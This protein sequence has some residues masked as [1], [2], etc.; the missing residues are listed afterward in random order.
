MNN[1][2]QFSF[3]KLIPLLLLSWLCQA[4]YA[5]GDIVSQNYTAAESPGVSSCTA[6]YNFLS[7]DVE[8]GKTWITGALPYTLTYRAP[9]R[10]NLTAAQNFEQPEITTAGWVDNYQSH[11]ITANVSST[12]QIKKVLG[13]YHGSIFLERSP[14]YIYNP[15][16]VG[17]PATKYF[18][19]KRHY[20]RLPGESSDHVFSEQFSAGQST[21]YRLY[22]SDP[23]AYVRKYGVPELSGTGNSYWSSDT[24]EYTLSRNGNVLTVSKYGVSYSFTDTS[25]EMSPN[26]SV[27]SSS[28]A[29]YIGVDAEGYLIAQKT[30]PSDPER[31]FVLST[32]TTTG[33]V[34]L[35]RVAQVIY[36]NGTKLTIEY[37]SNMNLSK[38]SDNRNNVLELS[39]DYKKS[40][41]YTQTV[42]ETR[43]VTQVKLTSGSDTQTAT[44]TYSDYNVKIPQTGDP[45]L[46]Y[47]LKTG[48]STISSKYTYGYARTEIGAL[49]KYLQEIGVTYDTSYGFPVL[50]KITNQLGKLEQQWDITQNYI[51]S[52]SGSSYTTAKTTLRSY[53]ANPVDVA[54]T[55]FDSTTVYDDV[56]KTI[57]LSVAIDGTQTGTSTL[58]TTVDDY[59]DQSEIA[60]TGFPCLSVNKYPVSKLKFN[61]AKGQLTEST[62]RNGNISTY[63][64]DANNRLKVFQEA[65]NSTTLA[66]T[67]TYTYGALDGGAIN[68]YLV[69]TLI[70]KP[71]V[72]ITNVVNARGQLKTQKLS[73]AQAG[74]EDRLTAYAYYEDAALS[75]FGLI[76][77]VDGPRAGNT[78]R[79]RYYYDN[80]GNLYRKRMDLNG[81][82]RSDYYV[83]YN[84]QGKPERIVKPTGL[85][86]KF[87][88]NADGTVQ[89]VVVGV[90]NTTSTIT[91]KTTSYTYDALKRVKTETSPDGEVTTYEYDFVG[92]PFKVENPDGSLQIKAYY[93]IGALKSD[94]LF[95]STATNLF[96]GA[97]QTLDI[98]GR[99]AVSQSGNSEGWYLQSY[100]YDENG[101]L[102]KQTKGVS[103]DQWTYDELNRVKT[104]T[105]PLGFVDSKSYDL[106]NN[107]KSI[108]D[109]VG[110]GSN[111]FEY[112]NLGVL[113]KETN[114]DFGVKEYSHNSGD[115]LTSAVHG[116]RQCDY[117]PDEL[118]RNQQVVCK[119]KDGSGVGS[120][121]VHDDTYTYD[122]S[123]FGRLD[124]VVSA[125]GYGVNTSYVYDGYDR[126]ISK[127]Q[128]N[129][130]LTVWNVANA[131][132]LVVGYEYSLGDKLK[133][134][135]LPS[136]K[137]VAY[138][139]DAS[140][141]LTDIQ[142][143]SQPILRNVAYNGGGQLTGWKWSN[144]NASYTL[145]YE[146]RKN[147]AIS[148]IT[149]KNRSNAT[150]YG[151]TYGFYS[152]G[153]IKRLLR[154]DGSN[155]NYTYFSN[156]WLK[157]E[158]GMN[159]TDAV[160]SIGYTY[161]QNGNRK[162]LTATGTPLDG[163]N[164]A[165]YAYTGNKLTSY[166][167]NGA[168]QILNYKSN[169]ELG[170]A[171]RNPVYDFAGRRKRELE[172][173]VARFF[174]YNHKNERTL[175]SHDDG[176]WSV[177]TTQYVYDEASHLIGEYDRYGN[178]KVEYV[179][180]GDKPVAAIYPTGIYYIVTDAA[181][182]PHRLMN[183]ADDQLVWAW[184]GSAFGTG[185]P[186]IQTV[187]F[188]LRFPGQ[189]Y[190]AESGQHY[191]LN[192]FYNPEL[193]RY[194]EPDPIGL[195]G[196][197]N[198]YAYAG[199]NPVS[200]V[201]PSGLSSLNI[202]WP[203]FNS[204]TTITERTLARTAIG[205]GGALAEPTPF[206]EAA[207]T[208][209][210]IGVGAYEGY[211]YF[212]Q[213]KE[214]V[215]PSGIKLEVNN[216][217]IDRFIFRGG[218]GNNTNFTP[219]PVDTGGLSYYL[220]PPAKGDYTFT[221]LSAVNSTK[222]LTAVV[223]AA[224]HASV[225]PTNRATM[226]EWI[227]SRPN[228][229]QAPHPYTL[230]MKG[231]SIRMKSGE[232]PW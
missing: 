96:T 6:G 89:S 230:L 74:S 197:L 208:V 222:V 3:L 224:N 62:D 50:R 162:T 2:T 66:R 79:V 169:A 49:K 27:T 15:S 9:L 94:E 191:N 185:V 186:T 8:T 86:S 85:V 122:Q 183:M 144:G 159:G 165:T 16:A 121:L 203:S 1:S 93:P 182:T 126:V 98:N 108:T 26:Q 146:G 149:S 64:Y 116:V 69:P 29:K 226:P 195:E 87:V 212:S 218:N 82:S 158:N 164:T 55:A 210:T 229:L 198:P 145:G 99:L 160:Y 36:S 163:I 153:L 141:H 190:D 37:D 77:A 4:A 46:A 105:D 7:G 231:I 161:D 76:S 45:A 114:S 202:N 25:Y 110:S 43:P 140:G 188:N 219:R 14:G 51:L 59:Y 184:D 111:P 35:G 130:S 156:G 187:T 177:N 18:S 22:T 207:M 101:N 170:L 157:T 138:N 221:T 147:G 152:N 83:G 118:E 100:E 133:K 78:D 28:Y 227:N 166:V 123:R 150:N 34:T 178:A 88:Y 48:E 71:D 107:V 44:F 124:T 115:Q 20:I 137:Q 135:T 168:T 60:V 181:N 56:N 216:P 151:L 40:I 201:D 73:S 167:K 31:D 38:V 228:A 42:A 106:N 204:V 205:W 72:T 23:V 103:V 54:Q 61:S 68:P 90:G 32:N 209:A 220:A 11:L 171:G 199:N 179:W 206:G 189:Y 132:A 217:Q 92:R 63:I 194:M 225:F 139:Y 125:S 143:D 91:G 113:A 19:F 17:E 127:S 80:Y 117:T 120:T 81:L 41:G 39:H 5:V 119:A 131:S 213:P 57:S 173:S 21:F 53:I 172:T 180:L 75:N 193:G 104:H 192:R 97:Y 102:K 174:A 47:L 84:S 148:S 70:E 215:T 112:K 24:G 175:K 176:S 12:T 58:T 232:T 136:G 30:T 52:S 196:G 129:K 214:Y 200:N 95:D 211:K 33:N 155:N 67:T 128:F 154:H 142:L 223:D 10:Q 65:S 134:L 109:A 13:G